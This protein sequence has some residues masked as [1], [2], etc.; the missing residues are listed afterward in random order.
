MDLPPGTTPTRSDA[1]F[2]RV[3]KAPAQIGRQF[4]P[5]HRALGGRGRRVRCGLLVEHGSSQLVDALEEA[6]LDVDEPAAVRSFG[7]VGRA[8]PV[9]HDGRRQAPELDEPLGGDGAGPRRVADDIV[10]VEERLEL[11]AELLAQRRRPL[12]LDDELGQDPVDQ[13]RC[14]LRRRGPV[15]SGAKTVAMVSRSW[16]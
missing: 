11:G 2:R 13:P 1:E 10:L 14:I 5:R 3:R 4:L 15:S 6:S 8:R 16:R 7:R 9:R 12:L